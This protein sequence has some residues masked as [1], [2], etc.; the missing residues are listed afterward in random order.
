MQKS[1]VNHLDARIKRLRRRHRELGKMIADLERHRDRLRAEQTQL[2]L[3]PRC[4]P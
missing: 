1:E 2:T 3:F 4:L